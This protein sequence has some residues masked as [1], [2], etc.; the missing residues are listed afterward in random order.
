MRLK[1]HIISF[2]KCQISCHYLHW[3]NSDAHFCEQQKVFLIFLQ[4]QIFLRKEI[5]L[6]FVCGMKFMLQTTRAFRI[7]ITHRLT[8]H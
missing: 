7:T 2:E 1:V 4:Y 3:F 5:A 8:L 6:N